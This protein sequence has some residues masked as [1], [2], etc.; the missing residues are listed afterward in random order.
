MSYALILK[1]DHGSGRTS[2]PRGGSELETM[3]PALHRLSG[4]FRATLCISDL[5]TD[6]LLNERAHKSAC[7]VLYF[8]EHHDLVQTCANA[9]ALNTFLLSGPFQGWHPGE[10]TYQAMQVHD[11]PAGNETARSI[12]NGYGYLVGYEG[13][14]ADPV[15]WVAEYMENHVSLMQRLPGISHIEVFTRIEPC[16]IP[17]IGL[18]QDWMLRN[19][20]CFNTRQEMD[21]ALHSPARA[22]LLAHRLGMEEHGGDSEHISVSFQ[23]MEIKARTSDA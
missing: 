6:P 8:R 1:R 14:P 2:G 20:A 9:A 16:V 11:F 10:L 21:A 12:R 22:A 7:L 4:L 18:G 23:S 17:S 13:Y 15:A 3:Q 5:L 19:I